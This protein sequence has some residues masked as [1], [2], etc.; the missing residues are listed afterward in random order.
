MKYINTK[1]NVRIMVDDDWYAMLSLVPW[2]IKKMDKRSYAVR[3]EQ[4]G[5]KKKDSGMHRIIMDAPKHLQVDH[6]N[7]NG[8]DNRRENLRLCTIQQN[9][10]NRGP[11]KNNKCGYKGVRF[12]PLLGVWIAEIRIEKHGKRLHIG[13]FKTAKEAA[14]A[15]NG[16]VVKYHG[17]FAYINKV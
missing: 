8:L 2:S 4:I 16:Q 10:F 6:I 1:N 7:G 15:Y 14:I 13:T 11:S 3:T 5:G 12:R 17:E 9:L